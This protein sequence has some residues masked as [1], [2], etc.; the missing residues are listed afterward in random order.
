MSYTSSLGWKYQTKVVIVTIDKDTNLQQENIIQNC[1]LFY[2]IGLLKMNDTARIDCK[3]HTKV[4]IVTSYKH[5][6]LQQ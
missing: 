2:I 6:S 5:I 4:V 1:N 3:Y